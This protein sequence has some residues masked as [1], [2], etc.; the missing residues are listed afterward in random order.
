MV[1]GKL[2]EAQVAHNTN[3]ARLSLEREKHD[4][5]GYSSLLDLLPPHQGRGVVAGTSAVGAAAAAAAAAAPGRTIVKGAWSTEEDAVVRHA[6]QVEAQ[7]NPYRRGDSLGR[8]EQRVN[9]RSV[10]DMIP[11]RTG[12][13]VRERWFNQLDPTISRLPWSGEEDSML[14]QVREEREIRGEKGRGGDGRGIEGKRGIGH[15]KGPYEPGANRQRVMN[16]SPRAVVGPF[17]QTRRVSVTLS[18]L[19][20]RVPPSPYPP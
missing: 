20:R 19:H 14:L 7:G 1:S 13:Q 2:K 8:D 11:G 3:V 10:A 9:W 4:C 17:T 6:V 12:K 16:G 15:A 5:T 18:L